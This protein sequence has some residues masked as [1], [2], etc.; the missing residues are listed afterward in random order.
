M[1]SSLFSEQIGFKWH[2]QSFFY[3]EKYL[4]VKKFKT[5]IFRELSGYKNYTIKEADNWQ[6]Q[7]ET[8]GATNL[9]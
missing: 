2:Y 5:K 3:K 7:P 6:T 4:L 9:H 1:F 8:K